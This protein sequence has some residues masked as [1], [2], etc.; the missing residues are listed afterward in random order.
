MDEPPVRYAT[1]SDG[2]SIAYTSIGT[3][4]A[5]VAIMPFPWT[6][7]EAAWRLPEIRRWHQRLA[8]RRRLIVYDSRGMGLSDRRSGPSSLDDLLRD[9]EA[10]VDEAALDPF[11]LLSAPTTGPVA[12]A[13][14]ARAPDRLSHL[15][16]LGSSARGADVYPPQIAALDA[17]REQDWELY[18]EAVAHTTVGWSEGEYAHRFAAFLR[19]C[20]TPETTR[21]FHATVRTIDVTPLLPTIAVPTLVLQRRDVV[22]PPLAVARA[23][24]ARIRGARLVLLEG[25]SPAPFIGD[26]EAAARA[27]DEF[28]GDVIT[29]PSVPAEPLDAACAP[30]VT[31]SP[32]ATAPLTILVTDVEGSTAL[33][34]RA[35]DSQARA[36][37]RHHDAIV[38][39][40]V[41]AHGGTEVKAMGDGFIVSFRAP[42]AAVACA[43]AIQRA[44]TEPASGVR[45]RIG[46]NAGEPIVEAGDLYGTAVNVAARVAALAAGGEIVVTD[47]VRQ[48]VAGKGFTFV[49]RGDASLRGISAPV[50][51]ADLRWTGD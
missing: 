31:N 9:L 14:A 27:I 19:Q 22:A 1:T 51:V 49:E 39:D 13:Y 41:R 25:S 12:V 46:I 10:V 34:E 36:A 44:L 15:I 11:A 40:A 50:R 17:L 7:L 45:V 35:G 42:S 28:L 32:A 18:T 48:L 38:R 23:L 43:I 20:A 33:A 26:M 3:G 2:V 29:D 37:L 4:P 30:A 21:A 16:V 24:A 8:R 6:H 5:V 47:V